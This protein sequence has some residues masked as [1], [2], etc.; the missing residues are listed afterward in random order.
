MRST[1][2]A[3]TTL[4][5]SFAEP[6]A[7]WTGPVDDVEIGDLG[8][9]ETGMRLSDW[10]QPLQAGGAEGSLKETGESEEVCDRSGS[11]S[12]DEQHRDRTVMQDVLYVAAHED[13]PD[14]PP[15]L[16]SQYDEVGGP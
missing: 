1:W 7:D 12:G 14:A 13:V 2:E 4:P 6:P 15:P 5:L 8:Y 11:K 3:W 9:S 10:E 16:R